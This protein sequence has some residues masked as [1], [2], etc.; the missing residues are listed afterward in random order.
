[1]MDDV[2]PLPQIYTT[3]LPVA[4]S[5]SLA[6]RSLLLDLANQLLMTLL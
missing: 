4:P 1:M 2:A 6:S 5:A 3:H